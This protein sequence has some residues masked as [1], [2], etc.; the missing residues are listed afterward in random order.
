MDGSTLHKLARYLIAFALLLSSLGPVVFAQDG[1][2]ALSSAG[3]TGY[4]SVEQ[5]VADDGNVFNKVVINGPPE[6]PAGYD[7]P[8]VDPAV[9][10]KKDAVV[11]LTAPA[12]NWS[13]GC[14]ATSAAMIAGYYDRGSYPNMYAGPTNGGV[15]PLDNSA[16]PDWVDAGGDTRHQCPL[17]ATHN[18]L[19]GRATR[20][21]VDDYWMWVDHAGPDPYVTN[22]WTEH[23]AADCTGDFMKTNRANSGNVDGSTTFWFA[24]SGAPLTA[25]EMETYGYDD[26][27]GGYGVKLFYQSRGYVVT[28]MYNQLIYGQGTN[29]TL[30]FTYAQYMAEIDAG[31][32]VMFHVEGHTMI[33]VGYDSSSN[34]MY[35]HDTWDYSNHTMT[36]GG[37]YSGMQHYG[38]TIVQLQAAAS[39]PTAPTGL[40]ATAVSQSQINLAWTDASNNETGFKIERSPFAP[41]SWSQIATVGAGV[42]TYPNTSLSAGTTYYY[43]VRAYN[44]AGDSAYS[45]EAHATTP[46]TV[47]WYYRY[48]PVVFKAYASGGGC[49]ID[50]SFNDSADGWYSHSSTW[51]YDSNY[52]Y[53][54]G[55]AGYFS[56]ASYAADFSNFDY[57]AAMLRYG[58]EDCANSL[59]FRGTPD[60]LTSSYGWYHEYKLSYSRD[61]YYSIW[62]RTYGGSGIPLVSWT[63]TSA[64][65]QGDAWNTLRAVAN[66]ASLSFYINGSLV[67]SGSDSSL[68]SGRAGVNMYAESSSGEELLVDWA[69]LCTLPKGAAAPPEF[70]PPAGPTVGGDENRHD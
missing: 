42:T 15:M 59:V 68:T 49:P 14:S 20:G 19:D 1:A 23:T 57:Q 2:P 35:I 9:E 5:V 45:N 40:T 12:F 51:Y 33:G 63:Y 37:Q 47:T 52:L 44:A 31:R 65:N 46:G 24:N 64:I 30:G 16:W 43:R 48:L 8:T 10:A 61:G 58:C 22:G 69:L 70:V 29:P 67:W 17:S 21:N 11:I 66:G 62:V 34:L 39:P 6:P 32:P 28:S 55:L 50:S 36:W 38:V 25:S 26:T 18:G 56:S 3:Q 54:Y 4:F 7:R 41:G 60:P 13:F 27:D 53:T